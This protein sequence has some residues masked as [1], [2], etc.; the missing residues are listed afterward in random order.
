MRIGLVLGAGAYPGHAW[1]VGVLHGLED[2]LGIDIRDATLIV[3]TSIGSITGGG[4]RGGFRPVDLAAA[5]L[6]TPK[7]PEGEILSAHHIDPPVDL[8]FIAD[9][10]PVQ[11]R[12]EAER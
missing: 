2:A 7:T 4:I 3:G 5:I 6:D 12:V 10:Q 1:H 8:V 11:R 9:N